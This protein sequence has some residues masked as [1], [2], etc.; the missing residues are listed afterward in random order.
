MVGGGGGLVE[1]AEVEEDVLD[2]EGG[3]GVGGG[4]G[5]EMAADVGD[6]LVRELAAGVE[7]GEAAD[8]GAPLLVVVLVEGFGVEDGGFEGG[9]GLEEAVPFFRGSLRGG[10]EMGAVGVGHEDL[11]GDLFVGAGAAG[12]ALQGGGH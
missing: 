7:A 9:E 10:G 2:V 1:E 3:E 8:E 5:V 4:E 6:E 12:P 11:F